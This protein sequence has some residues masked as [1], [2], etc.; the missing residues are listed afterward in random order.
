MKLLGIDIETGD[1][2]KDNQ[3]ITEMGAV[4]YDTE[5]KTPVEIYS[6]LINTVGKT[7]TQEA[8]EYTG[9]TNEMVKSYGIKPILVA[10]NIRLLIERSDFAVAHNG[11]AFDKP[12]VSKFL[13]DHG[14]V[15]IKNIPWI[16][17]MI[18]IEYPGN[19]R[20]RNLTYLQAFHGFA[21]PGHRAI[22]DV[23]AMLR[24]LMSYD[25]N[26]VIDVAKSP[27]IELQWSAPYPRTGKGSPQMIAF[28]EIKDKVK[29]SGFHWEPDRE[30]WS[31]TTKELLLRD[32]KLDF[33]YKV[34]E[35]KQ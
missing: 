6:T 34:I 2:D 25:L 9:I 3:F 29:G 17:T 14:E 10:Q 5:L 24:I 12:I 27:E 18:D 32:M 19:C 23:M 35:V 33:E 20:N 16:D 7:I 22:F 11:N 21:Y 31:K 8:T 15:S 28:E 4:L 30:L 26:R 1:L 13:K